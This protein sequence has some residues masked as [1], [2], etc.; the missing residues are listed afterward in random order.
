MR[1][2]RIWQLQ[3]SPFA[4]IEFQSQYGATE[5]PIGYDRL[6]VVLDPVPQQATSGGFCYNR[7]Q[8]RRA[9]FGPNGGV[10]LFWG[11]AIVIW[12]QAAA[13]WWFKLLAKVSGCLSDGS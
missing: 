4:E 2:R 5:L 9:G 7:V 8:A 10:R 13:R 11:S 3:A 6:A 12:R 1:R